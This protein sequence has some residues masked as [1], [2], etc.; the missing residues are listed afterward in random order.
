MLRHYNL[1]PL[2]VCIQSETLKSYFVI[3]F[4]YL[5]LSSETFCVKHK[6]QTA[7]FYILQPCKLHETPLF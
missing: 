1:V 6:I 5:Y 3:F 7:R 4:L 2:V